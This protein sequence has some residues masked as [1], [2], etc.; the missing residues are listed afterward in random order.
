MI[1][2]PGQDVLVDEGHVGTKPEHVVVEPWRRQSPD[3]PTTQSVEG[4]LVILEGKGPEKVFDPRFLFHKL[5]YLGRVIKLKKWITRTRWTS[6]SS[7]S[8]QGL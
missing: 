2:I 1:H 4:R 6:W 5:M 7:N 8:R 3:P